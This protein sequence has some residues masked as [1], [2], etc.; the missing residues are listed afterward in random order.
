M[1]LILIPNRNHHID[2]LL[3]P[4][5]ALGAEKGTPLSIRMAYGNPYSLNACSNTVNAVTAPVDPNPSQANRY[6]DTQIPRVITRDGKGG[7]S[8]AYY[9]I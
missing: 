9:P 3:N 6:T 8:N 4:N 1:R 7:N 2:N 5:S